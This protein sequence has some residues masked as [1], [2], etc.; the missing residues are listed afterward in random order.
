MIPALGVCQSFV[1]IIDIARGA[2]TKLFDYWKAAITS[3]TD[4]GKFSSDIQVD[5]IESCLCFQNGGSG[6]LECLDRSDI[7]SKHWLLF[8]CITA[9]C[10]SE[11]NVG[12]MKFLGRHGIR[13]NLL[14]C[15]KNLGNPAIHNFQLWYLLLTSL[16]L[17]TFPGTCNDSIV[18]IVSTWLNNFQTVLA[19]H[20][21]A[22]HWY[23]RIPE[24]KWA[25]FLTFPPGTA[26]ILKDWSCCDYKEAVVPIKKPTERRV[27]AVN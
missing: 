22:C 23:Q 2:N 18:L 24:M 21:E 26:A 17:F 14:R 5:R 13:V 8:L 16:R 10:L 3:R 20:Q 12:L 25:A 27:E 11:W 6:I 9:I 15:E 4:G 1:R 19:R 7:L